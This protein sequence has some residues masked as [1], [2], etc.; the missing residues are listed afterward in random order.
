LANGNKGMITRN[1]SLVLASL[2]ILPVAARADAIDD[3]VE[4]IRTNA[5]VPG[6]SI[7]VVRNGELAKAKGYGLADVELNV[8]ATEKTVYQWASVTKQFTA[9]AILLLAQ[10]GKVKLEDPIAAYYPQAPKTWKGVTIRHLLNHT[11]GIHSYTDLPEFRKTLR[12]DYESDELIGLVKDMDLDFKPGEKWRYSNTGYYLLGLV[13]EK[14]SGQS[15]ADF[16]KK[17]IFEP[18]GMSTARVNDQSDLIR[19]RATGYY[20]VS[21]E[22]KRAV[23]VSPSQPYSAGALV[24]TVLDLAKWDAALYTDKLLPSSVR[25]AMWQA[26]ELVD[27]KRQPY[28]YGWQLGKIR[29]HRFVG[30]GGGIDGFSTFIL[31][32]IDDE[33]TVVVLM[34]GGGISPQTVASGIAARYVPDL[35]LASITSSTDPHPELSARLKRCLSELAEKKD[36]E[37]LTDGFRQNF[38]RSRRRHGML[39]EDLKDL[40]DFTFVLSEK[41]EVEVEEFGAQVARVASYKVTSGENRVRFYTFALTSDNKVTNFNVSEE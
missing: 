29:A 16:L 21:N 17:R 7:A 12:K 39:K 15:Y 11:S 4:K 31:R 13:I 20:L 26:T 10:D 24:G 1:I 19:H 41:P 32:L 33:L 38:S 18:L 27:G 23:F 37:I 34:N 36:S 22:V 14:A 2:L 25:E 28:G 9:A 5:Q 3:Y 35:S 6:L 30:H 8:P 40:K